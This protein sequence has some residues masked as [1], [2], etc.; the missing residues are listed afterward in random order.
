MS[1][2][3]QGTFVADRLPYQTRYALVLPYHPADPDYLHA[4]PDSAIHQWGAALIE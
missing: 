1:R 4:W 3:T 2:G